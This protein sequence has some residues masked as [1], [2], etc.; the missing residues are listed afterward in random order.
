MNNYLIHNIKPLDY[1]D[2]GLY[3]VVLHANDIPPHIGIIYNK[4]YFSLTVTGQTL[5]D[6]FQG[7][8]KLIHRKQIKT[9]FI[10]LVEVLNSMENIRNSFIEKKRVQGNITCLFPIKKVLAA[11]YGKSIARA[12]FIYEVVPVLY[13]TKSIEDVYHLNMNDEIEMGTF[14]FTRYTMDDIL[15]RIKSYETEELC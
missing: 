9:L 7:L 4:K 10:K 5:G 8:K 13:K 12:K 3:L 15:D 14:S 1:I 11:M 2:S 6:D